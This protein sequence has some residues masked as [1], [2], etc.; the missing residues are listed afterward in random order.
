MDERLKATARNTEQLEVITVPSYSC[1]LAV[2]PAFTP[3]AWG[4]Y[5]PSSTYASSLLLHKGRKEKERRGTGSPPTLT[6]LTLAMAAQAATWSTRH[7][8]T[9]PLRDVSQ[10][11]PRGTHEIELHLEGRF[12]ST[13]YHHLAHSRTN[14][15]ETSIHHS[16]ADGPRCCRPRTHLCPLL[17]Q[18]EDHLSGHCCTPSDESRELT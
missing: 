3:S 14:E 17:R 6:G 15:R 16:P 2:V 13:T 7:H 10:G 8:A 5:P 12:S 4:T 9:P 18:T 11:A 1:N